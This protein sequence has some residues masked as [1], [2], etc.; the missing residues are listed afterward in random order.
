MGKRKVLNEAELKDM[1]LPE[2]GEMLGRVV[3]LLGSDHL[4][5]N[6]TDGKI[7][8]GRIRGRLKR[9][10]WIREGDV[11]LLAPWDFKN[12]E[13]CDILWRYTIA[14]V[15]WLRANNYITSAM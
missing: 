14:Q 8:L 10:I 15:D 9:R 5:V 12:D 13:K 11:V 6:C 2:Q 3:K 4:M 1:L 7:R